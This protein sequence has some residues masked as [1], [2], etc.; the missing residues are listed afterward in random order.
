VSRG[1]DDLGSFKTPT[2]RNIAATAPYMHDGS[3]ETLEDVIDFYN[4]GGRDKETDPLSGFQSGGI[5][6][7]N[8]TDAEKQDLVAFMKALTSPALDQFTKH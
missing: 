1:F 7:L 6:P 3:L 4:N 8:L 5:R 2:L